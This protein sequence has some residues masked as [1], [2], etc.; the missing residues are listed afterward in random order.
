MLAPSAVELRRLTR[1]TRHAELL[2]VESNTD[3]S[4]GEY[5]FNHYPHAE[6]R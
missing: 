2:A 6:E 1:A 3:R 5:T 4:L